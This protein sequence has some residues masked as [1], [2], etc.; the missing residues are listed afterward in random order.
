MKFYLETTNYNQFEFLQDNREVTQNHVKKIASSFEKYGQLVP[1]LCSKLNNGKLYIIDGQYRFSAAKNL[2]LPIKYSVHD[3]L[4]GDDV[5]EINVTQKKFNNLDWIKRYAKQNIKDYKLLLYNYENYKKTFGISTIVELFFDFDKKT[6][7]LSI[8]LRTGKYKINVTKGTEI[9]NIILKS[10]AVTNN[11]NFL[12][13]IFARA[14]QLF[15]HQNKNKF[16]L[17]HFLKNLS[18][19]KL[20]VYHLKDDTYNE[21]KNVYNYNLKNEI[22][23][24]I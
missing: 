21:I 5:T 23:K 11:K 24:A 14:I 12:K 17:K 7:P 22:N 8:A 3:N 20:N 18:V 16:K 1:I 15:L 19:K 4:K 9:I 10:Y 2:N 13:R 6:L